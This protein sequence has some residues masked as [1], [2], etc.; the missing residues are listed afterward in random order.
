[1]P[2]EFA[3]GASQCTGGAAQLQFGAVALGGVHRLDGMH[4]RVMMQAQLQEAQAH[5]VQQVGTGRFV[6]GFTQPRQQVQALLEHLLDRLGCWNCALLLRNLLR[7]I[8][9]IGALCHGGRGGVQWKLPM[10]R[11]LWRRAL[12]E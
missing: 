12:R 11:R 3:L 5:P 4:Q 2:A 8:C 7:R 6:A 1:M 9:R 10:A